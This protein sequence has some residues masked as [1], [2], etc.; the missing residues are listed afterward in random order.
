ML[1]RGTVV[2]TWGWGG[3]AHLPTDPCLCEL[4]TDKL[5]FMLGSV[6]LITSVSFLL[7]NKYLITRD[8]WQGKAPQVLIIQQIW[9]KQRDYFP[10]RCPYVRTSGAKPHCCSLP[11]VFLTQLRDH[12]SVFPE[13][14]VG[15]ERA[16]H[17][18]LQ[19]KSFIYLK[20]KLDQD[21]QL[22]CLYKCSR[23]TF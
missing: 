5:F 9:P 3:A 2:G 17:L 14:L 4:M 12:L 15:V 1:A 18:F 23:N 11:M 22:L 19:I 16:G 21:F 10:I 8:V 13:S 6:D 20:K 7:R